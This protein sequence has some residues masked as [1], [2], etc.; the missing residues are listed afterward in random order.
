MK[1]T[2]THRMQLGKGAP[3][4]PASPL[5]GNAGARPPAHA[6]PNPASPRPARAAPG[7]G[8]PQ[9]KTAALVWHR[10]GRPQREGKYRTPPLDKHQAGGSQPGWEQLQQGWVRAGQSPPVP[11]L[12]GCHGAA[13]WGGHPPADP[14]LRRD[15]GNRG[16]GPVSP[17]AGAAA[18]FLHHEG[19]CRGC[20][21]AR[22]GQVPSRPCSTARCARTR[23]HRVPCH[24]CPQTPRVTGEQQGLQAAPVPAH[25]R[26]WLRVSATS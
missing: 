23:G 9:P 16:Q 15:E 14:R 8:Q 24:G 25:P 11:T 10:P 13:G 12:G 5:Q 1:L 4:P 26:T 19:G 2:P 3:G 22:P 6:K 20:Q 17:L 21:L 18:P 7:Q